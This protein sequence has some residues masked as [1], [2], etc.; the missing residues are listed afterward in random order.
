MKKT[1]Q[2]FLF[3]AL[4]TTLVLSLA[5]FSSAANQAPAKIGKP[6]I[7]KEADSLTFTWKNFS[8]STGVQVF[9]VSQDGERIYLK[10]TRKLSYTASKLESNTDYT[11]AFRL[12]DKDGETGKT[13]YG[14]FLSVTARTR[15]EIVSGLSFSKAGSDSITVKWSPVQGVDSYKISYAV[16]GSGKY[17]EAGQT[18]GTS[19]TLKKLS[20]KQFYKIRVCAVSKNT[21][22]RNCE[23]IRLCTVPQAPSKPTATASTVSSVSLKWAKVPCANK[24]YLYISSSANGKYKLVRET[25]SLSCVYK[26]SSPNTKVYFKVAAGFENELQKVKSPLSKA[27][28]A[29]TAPITASASRTSI[30]IGEFAELS[31][32]GYKNPKWTSSNPSVVE[33]RGKSRAFANKSGTATLTATCAKAKLQIKITVLG[34]LVPYKACVYDVTNGRFAYRNGAN[35]KA[36]PGSI[37][38]LV[39]ALVSSKYISPD[40]VLTVGSELGLLEGDASRSGLSYGEKFKYKDLLYAMLLKSGCDAAYTIAVNC[41]RIVS[42]QPNMGASNAKYYFVSMMNDYLKSIGASSSHFTNPHG[43]PNSNHYTTAND[44]CL[45]G[46]RVLKN[47]L[48]CDVISHYTKT[49]TAV[50]GRTHTFTTTNSMV[51]PYSGYYN[52][53]TFGLKTGTSSDTYRSLMTSAKKNG[54]T[55]ITVVLGCE[56]SAARYNMTSRMYSRF[57]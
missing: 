15:P 42:G 36:Y 5:F 38:K 49:V 4:L 34:T 1:K 44:L 57:L 20:A 2:L 6:Q 18:K 54:H 7:Q 8:G 10:S 13:V 37:T 23:P 39:T 35:Q 21:V 56:T 3:T 30:Y 9:A 19:F 55:I 25:T 28:E 14:S 31:V 26:L 33:I 47:S 24:Y 41:A 12:Y 43:Y 45:V 40:K 53:Y 52:P 11:F 50:T 16:L 32:K 27:L 17:A 48:L 29:K 46:Q 22:S 51:N